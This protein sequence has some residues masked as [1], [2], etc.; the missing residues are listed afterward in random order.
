MKIAP[1]YSVYFFLY[2]TFSENLVSDEGVRGEGDE[3]D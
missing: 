2:R 3:L 1:P